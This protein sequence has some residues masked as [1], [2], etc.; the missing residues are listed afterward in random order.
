MA[1]VGALSTTVVILIAALIVFITIL[2]GAALWWPTRGHPERRSDLGL[3]LMSGAVI[4]FAVLGVQIMFDIRN[5]QAADESQAIADKQNLQFQ[6]AR[7][8]DLSS[9]ALAGQDLAGFYLPSKNMTGANLANVVATGA[10]VNRTDLSRSNLTDADF[11]GAQLRGAR[12][13]EAEGPRVILKDTDLRG[14]SLERANLPNADLSGAKLDFAQVGAELE[15]ATLDRARMPAADLRGADLR[16]ASLV[17]ADMDIARLQGVDMR[18]AKLAGAKLKW[19]VYDAE[20]VWPDGFKVDQCNLGDTCRYQA[21]G[22]QVTRLDEFHLLLTKQLP[23]GWNDKSAEKSKPGSPQVFLESPTRDQNFIASS[24]P[25]SG[26]VKGYFDANRKNNRKVLPLYEELEI[27]DVKMLGGR[28]AILL[29]FRWRPERFRVQQLGQIQ[30]Y[31]AEEGAGYV[32]TFTS[33]KASSAR[34]NQR[35]FRLFDTLLVER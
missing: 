16:D 27:E 34:V 28:D 3:A 31:Y 13:L 1:T 17:N 18:G 5:Q 4:A 22:K 29:R 19:A 21:Q 30:I 32:F 35:A 25:W 11:T 10:I 9:I 6:V 15:D 12:L 26:D 33:A 7:Q 8:R 20:T 23:T 2:P 24:E 14:A